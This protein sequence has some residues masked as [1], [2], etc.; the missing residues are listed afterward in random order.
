[1]RA[2]TASILPLLTL[3]CSPDAG[4]DAK[5]KASAE[6]KAAPGK[7]E[8]LA[9]GEKLATF[10][11]PDPTRQAFDPS[12]MIRTDG[13]SV[14]RQYVLGPPREITGIWHDGFE[15]SYFYEGA[16]DLSSSTSDKDMPDIW[17]DTDGKIDLPNPLRSAN[18]RIAVIGR[19]PTCGTREPPFGY[20]HLGMSKRLIVVDRVIS[21]VRID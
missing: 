21:V 18:Y 20:G 2:I 15:E 1:M 9:S 8:V 11:L 5:S 17:L 14:R 13:P 6:L 12:C 3:A 10:S 7:I 16:K 4:E 19:E